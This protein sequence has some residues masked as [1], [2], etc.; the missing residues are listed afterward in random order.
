MRRRYSALSL[1]AGFE[2]QALEYLVLLLTIETGSYS[3]SVSLSTW[4]PASDFSSMA[5]LIDSKT[6]DT[7]A[8][9]MVK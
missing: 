2:E 6:L 4:N 5:F 7:M 1:E 3:S 8:N 9:P